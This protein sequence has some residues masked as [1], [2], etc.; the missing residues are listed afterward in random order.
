MQVFWK[1]DKYRKMR[2]RSVIL[3]LNLV[4]IF[5]TADCGSWSAA[6]CEFK[7]A[8]ARGWRPKSSKPHLL[9]FVWKFN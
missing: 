3:A 6:G 2:M 1:F 9:Q 7:W 8:V 5:S 4:H